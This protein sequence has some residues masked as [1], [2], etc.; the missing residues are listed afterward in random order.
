MTTDELVKLIVAIAGLI[1][2][3]GV[4]LIAILQVVNRNAIREVHLS[5]NSRL[6]QLVES[7]S[8]AARIEGH[9]EGV[10]AGKEE[11]KKTE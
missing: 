7:K 5:L 3:I 8:S 4:P 1:S 2:A 6:D 11:L 9:A 10:L